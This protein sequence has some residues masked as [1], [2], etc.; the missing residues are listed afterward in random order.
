MCTEITAV[1]FNN[2]VQTLKSVAPVAKSWNI[3]PEAMDNANV[4]PVH[5]FLF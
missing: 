4:F 3:M 1:D 5:C 2:V